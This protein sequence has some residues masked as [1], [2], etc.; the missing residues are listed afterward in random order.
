MAA[1]G[2]VLVG[3]LVGV[4]LLSLAPAA[5]DETDLVARGI[6]RVCP[7]PTADADDTDD[8]E[9]E[10]DGEVPDDPRFPD[11]GRT[12][13]DAIDCAAAYGLVSGF[14]DGT[15]RPN[16][17]ITREQMASFIAAWLRTAT[18]VSLKVPDEP[19]FDDVVGGVHAAAIDALAA[20][21]I[22]GGRADG[23]FGPTET[24]TRG[25]F[26]RAV[27]NAI[28]YADIFAIDGPLPPA[29]PDVAFTD[30]FGTTFEDTIHRLAG[31]GIAL[32]TGDGAFS[33]THPVTRGQLSTFLMRS[34]D[35]LDEY[36]RWR[37]TALPEV[38]MAAELQLVVAL[39]PDDDGDGD[40][41]GGDGNGGDGSGGDGQEGD[42]EPDPIFATVGEVT[43]GVDA[44]GA[45][46]TYELVLSEPLGPYASSPGLTLHL[47]DPAT[48]PQAVLVLAAGDELDA[49]TDGVVSGTVFEAASSVR[50]AQLLT[51]LDRAYLQLSSAAF[52][53]G[54]ARGGLVLAPA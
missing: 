32:G 23:T 15:F 35:H 4:L 48:A 34:A 19:R 5:A 24:L 41:S 40:G 51:D 50:F 18:G 46:L 43:L 6:E 44:F 10:Q 27:A 49:A 52:P 31:V 26:T 8:A 14:G 21:D 25:Q 9:G 13:A 16:E 37:P 20:V 29:D 28:S 30:T 33:P 3:L 53:E 54:V 45:T 1:R 7:V 47:G 42:E 36:Q 2:R 17:P 22:I 11:I 38:A 39:P 12:H